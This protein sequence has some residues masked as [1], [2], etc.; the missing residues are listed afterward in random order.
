LNRY[1]AVDDCGNIINPLIVTGQVHGGVAQGVGQALYEQAVYDSSGQLLSGT[2]MD[3]ALPKAHQLVNYET[4]HTITP[5]PHN[6]L[7]VKGIG[8]AGTIAS[9]VAVAN[10][11]MD[12]L[13]PY[14]VKHI[15]T[16]L[17]SEKVWNAIHGNGRS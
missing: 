12:A 6:P 5:C 7:G 11:V 16:P 1:I 9:T 10:A 4:A 14:G 2:M 13:K 17:T 8:E 15:D 3:Y